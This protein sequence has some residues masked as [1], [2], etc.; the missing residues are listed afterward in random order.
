MKLIYKPLSL[1]VGVLGGIVAGAVFKQV[2][3]VVAGEEDAPQATDED[4]TWGEV[5]MAAAVQGAVFA[6]VKAAV[7]RAGAKGV[8]KLTGSWPG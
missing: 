4:R 3:K 6:F 2:W 8:Q 7:D 5:L 1:L